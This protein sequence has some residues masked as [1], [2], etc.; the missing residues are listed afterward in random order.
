MRQLKDRYIYEPNL[1]PLCDASM[2]LIIIFIMT[3]PAVIWTGIKVDATRAQRTQNQVEE[4]A[5]QHIAI[6][7]TSQGIYFNGYETHLDELS[8][9]IES[10]LAKKKE[11]VVIILP[12]DDVLLSRVVAVFDVAKIAGAEKLALL[13][14]LH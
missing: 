2:T 8:S 1:T 12:D 4:T 5:E 9:K 7:I 13:K 11:K 3:L 14:P 10:Q 6:S